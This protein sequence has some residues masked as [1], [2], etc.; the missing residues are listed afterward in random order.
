MDRSS[1]T[2]A[3]RYGKQV[4]EEV[5]EGSVL[6]TTDGYALFIL[7]YLIYCEGERPDLMVVHPGWL[8][9]FDPLR[10]QILEQYPDLILPSPDLVEKYMSRADDY[11]TKKYLFMQSILDANNAYRPVYWGMI[12]ANLPFLGNLI[13]RGILYRYSHESATLNAQALSENKEF[14]ENERLLSVHDPAMINDKLVQEIYPVELNNQ[15]LMFEQ[16][17]RDDLA[18]WA[19]ELALDFNPEYPVSRYNLGRL[20]ARE[21][22]YEKAVEEYKRAVKGN[23]YMA[24]AYYNLGN[25]YGHLKRYDD[26]FLAY[27]QAVRMYGRYFQALTAMGRMHLLAGQNEKASEKFKQALEIEPGYVFAL[28]GL[29][30]AYVQ[31]DQLKEAKEIVDKALEIEPASAPALFTLAQYYARIGDEE[32]AEE[33]LRRCVRIG[34]DAY[35]DDAAS[36]EPLRGTAEKLSAVEAKY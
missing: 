16:L 29:A 19:I 9:V 11:R 1:H 8:A 5:P 10:S 22:N 26:A 33:A 4:L 36:V 32:K 25:A 3:L 17:G 30:S 23:P 21:G 12:P 27:R 14:W 24:V 2:Y 15:G 13:P 7:W 18:R 35:I 6:F 28:R 31:M 20:E 34:G